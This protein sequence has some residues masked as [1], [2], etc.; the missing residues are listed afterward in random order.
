MDHLQAAKVISPVSPVSLQK[1][2]CPPLHSFVRVL[3]SNLAQEAS[4][5]WI[6][7]WQQTC[8]Q[9]WDI[10]GYLWI[11]MDIYGYFIRFCG[12][13]IVWETPALCVWMKIQNAGVRT[14]M[15]SLQIWT[16]QV[17]V[18]ETCDRLITS[19]TSYRF[20]LQSLY[21]QTDILL[22]K[23]EVWVG[24]VA[25]NPASPSRKLWLNPLLLARCCMINT[26]G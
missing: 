4:S 14:W 16:V 26:G 12:S 8:W 24:M 19:Q 11:S 3:S 18:S 15:G 22:K 9:T 6:F 25:K 20:R 10:Y 17:W 21:W 23:H 2:R 5:H 1:K 7:L 13:F